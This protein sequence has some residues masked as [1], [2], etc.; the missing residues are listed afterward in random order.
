MEDEKLFIAKRLDVYLLVSATDE[1]AQFVAQHLGIA[2]RDDD[3]GVWFGS[4]APDASLKFLDVLYLVDEDIVVFASIEVL[5]YV[6]VEVL[7]I[8]DT[9]KVSFLLIYVD[10]VIVRI[11]CL[12]VTY[13]LHHVA[14]AYTTLT[15]QYDDCFLSKIFLYLVNVC[16]TDDCSHNFI[17]YNGYFWQRY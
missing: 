5:I 11:A 12:L 17:F 1:G 15:Y 13:G 16:L 14:F 2:T 7:V 4:K 6:L 10:D 8:L 3:V 9:V